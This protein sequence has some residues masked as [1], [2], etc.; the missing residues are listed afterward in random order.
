MRKHTK[1]LALTVVLAAAGWFAGCNG[2]VDKE[3]NVVLE[4][5][6]LT[7]APIVGA[8]DTVTGACVFTITNASATFENKPKNTLAVVSPANDIIL[9]DVVVVYA[10]DDL[11]G[12][13]EAQFGVGGSVTANGTGTGSF[14]V[15]NAQDLALP[16][17]EGHTASLTLTFRGVTVSGDPVSATTGGSLTVNT[18]PP[19]AP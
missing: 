3:P 1:I 13:G 11:T 9:R 15:V 17:R 8:T 14:A 16:S 6:T 19:A 18:C 2:T 7:I 10:W 5:K 12:V 4:V